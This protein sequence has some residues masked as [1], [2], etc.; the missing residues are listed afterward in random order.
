MSKLKGGMDLFVVMLKLEDGWVGQ[1][2][3]ERCSNLEIHTEKWSIP[4]S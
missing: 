2:Q 1:N 4:Y 3:F